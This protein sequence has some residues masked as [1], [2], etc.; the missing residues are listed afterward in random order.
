MLGYAK[1]E[2]TEV[3]SLLC[4]VEASPEDIKSINKAIDIL[5]GLIAEGYID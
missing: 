2:I 3:I 4:G 5:D 1:S